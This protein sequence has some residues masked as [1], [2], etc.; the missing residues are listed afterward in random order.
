[1]NPKGKAWLSNKWATMVSSVVRRR[2]KKLTFRLPWIEEN[3]DSKQELVNK[4]KLASEGSNALSKAV[5]E[6]CKENKVNPK[7]RWKENKVKEDSYQ[8][9]IIS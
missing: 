9:D 8:R 7:K 3:K 2:Q 1:M 5:I 4:K 6:N